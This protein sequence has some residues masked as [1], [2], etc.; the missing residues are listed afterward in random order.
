MDKQVELR[1]ANSNNEIIQ[2][3]LNKKPP[4]LEDSYKLIYKEQEDKRK[5]VLSR[6][7]P[8]FS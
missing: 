1:K 3:Y 8:N 5:A 4:S 2:I 6:Y 7:L